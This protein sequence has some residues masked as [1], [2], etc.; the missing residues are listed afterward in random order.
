MKETQSHCSRIIQQVA[1]ATFA[2]ESQFT[3]TKSANLPTGLLFRTIVTLIFGRFANISL[4]FPGARK[5]ACLLPSNCNFERGHTCLIGNKR[6]ARAAFSDCDENIWI[7]FE[8]HFRHT[9]IIQ[10]FFNRGQKYSH[11]LQFD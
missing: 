6:C 5:S 10:H 3:D 4:S 11:A 9:C 2:R 1:G 8:L 7:F